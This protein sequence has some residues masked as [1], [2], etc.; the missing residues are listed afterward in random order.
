MKRSLLFGLVFCLVQCINAQKMSPITWTAFG[1]NFMV[2]SAILVEDDSEDTFL[3]NDKS[4]YISVMSLESDGITKEELKTLAKD[5]AKDEGV[6]FVDKPESIELPQFHG[7]FFRGTVE[8]DSC[9]YA[10]Y[11]TKDAGFSFYLSLLFDGKRH[12][13]AQ[14]VLKSFTIGVDEE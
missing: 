12:K 5:Y 7:T 14:Q 1:L 3:L 8:G 6:K 4:M 11:M 9:Y 10:C 2:P 13:E